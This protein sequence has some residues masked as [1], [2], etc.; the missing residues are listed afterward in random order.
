MVQQLRLYRSSP[1]VQWLRLH[2]QCRVMGLILVWGAEIPHAAW[3][4]QKDFCLMFWPSTKQTAVV[5]LLWFCSLCF[6]PLQWTSEVA[7]SCPTLCDPMDCS[8]PGSSIHGIFQARVLEWVAIS[9]SRGSSQPEDRTQ[10]SHIA[11]RRFAVWATRE[12]LFL[13]TDWN[14]FH[15]SRLKSNATSP[16]SPLMM[17]LLFT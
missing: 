1:V 14:S 10:V 6:L 9:F 4:S 8:L 7:Q 3:H 13:S 11:G 15:T 5:P 17:V 2:L 12:S 16:R